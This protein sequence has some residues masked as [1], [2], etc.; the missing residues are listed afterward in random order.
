MNP[1][2]KTKK[3]YKD[4]SGK[5]GFIRRMFDDISDRY[6]LMNRIISLGLDGVWRRRTVKPHSHDKLVL[7]ICS[8]TG[9]MTKELLNQNEFDGFIVLADF[10]P[11][12]HKLARQ[13]L[14]GHDN[15]CFVNCDAEKLPFKDAVFDGIV[16]GY[17]LRNLGDLKAFG[18]ETGRTVK[19]TGLISILDMAHPPN[20]VIAWLFHLYF[21]KFTPW[22]SRLFT[23]KKYAYKYLPIS[24][25]TFL[26]QPDV[27]SNLKGERFDGKYKNVFGGI[28]AIYRL[29]KKA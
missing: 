13:K 20:K 9:D 15:I 26:K 4:L 22:F 3:E 11:E 6:D 17:S 23:K 2:I 24:L 29:R 21:Y 19:D 8:G 28:V 7:D 14:H 1:D 27:L 25:R 5:K 12:M 16:S 10:S 18:F